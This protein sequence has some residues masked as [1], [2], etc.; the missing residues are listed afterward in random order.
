MKAHEYNR[1][2]AYE[3]E[4][5]GRSTKSS[6]FY[7][8]VMG[9][10]LVL[11]AGLAVFSV[12]QK[13]F[14]LTEDALYEDSLE[15]FQLTV[16]NDDY[17]MPKSL[18]VYGFDLVAEPY[19]TTK[20]TVNNALSEDSTFLFTLSDAEGT[21]IAS[22]MGT[23]FEFT[24]EK[25]GVT[26]YLEIDELS[27][28]ALDT[29]SLDSEVVGKGTKYQ[30]P[31]DKY[32][33]VRSGTFAV[34]CKY[35]RRE[36]RN[37]GD[38][39][40][41]KFLDAVK[42]MYSTDL[43][44]GV[45]TYGPDFTNYEAITLKHMSYNF[46]SGM[47]TPFH[48]GDS[49][50]TAHAAFSYEFEKSMQ[51]IDPSLA[52]PYWDYFMDAELYGTDWL[53]KSPIYSDTMFSHGNPDNNYIVDSGPLAN[54]LVPNDKSIWMSN[55]YGY[56]TTN[57]NNNPYGYVQRAD[58]I[59]GLALSEMNLPGCFEASGIVNTTSLANLRLAA[60]VDFHSL[61]HT[62]MGGVF[63]C[64][65]TPNDYMD[66]FTNSSDFLSDVVS[67]SYN[68]WMSTYSDEAMSCP[69][70]CEVGTAFESCVCSCSSI[71]MDNLDWQTA[72]DFI[73][74]YA[75]FNGVVTGVLSDYLAMDENTG[76]WTLTNDEEA[77]ETLVPWLVQYSCSPGI[78]TQ[79]TASSS[80]TNDPIFS[81]VHNL[82]ERFFHLYRVSAE[83][84]DFDWSWTDDSSCYGRSWNDTLPFYGFDIGPDS[85]SPTE[86][87]TNEVLF[88]IFD[89]NREELPYIFE[90]VDLSWCTDYF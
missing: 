8:T 45:D 31:M 22:S 14:G 89:P 56:I 7:R 90:D 18:S 63:S 68:L 48:D 39:D 54:L 78:M 64:P 12:S 23:S 35:V 27:Q 6:T 86:P 38:S 17:D 84:S 4:D 72:S 76:L 2:P 74:D 25:G 41:T 51:T 61:I 73:N 1:I 3:G 28:E 83:F 21:E 11:L 80:S 79:F 30:A 46:G 34:P 37:L 87:Y 81:V 59:C 42:I 60:E 19:R 44:E 13:A 20:V 40:L 85:F 43:K 33:V 67:Q 50:Y 26:M 58:Q 69:D 66:E 88:S 75:T 62:L 24:V 9:G 52:V 32:S 53:E 71:D 49:F 65:Y 15:D 70:S 16:T 57:F 82:F 10:L 36:I 29:S 47:C 5:V 77:S 55:S